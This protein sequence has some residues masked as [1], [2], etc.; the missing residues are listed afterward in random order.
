[1]ER[2]GPVCPACFR[3]VEEGAAYCG[4]CGHAI[5]PDAGRQPRRRPGLV[6]ILAVF[7]F[8]GGAGFLLIAVSVFAAFGNVPTD[9]RPAD[10]LVAVAAGLCFALVASAQIAGGIGL[11]RL[12]PHG[13]SIQR[14]FAILGLLLF[15]IG[16]IV[17]VVI[18]AYLNTAG[19]KL[20]F[21]RR[22]VS[23]LTEVEY[24]QLI[25]TM[26]SSSAA[27][28]MMSVLFGC[29]IIV[30][31]VSAV[32]VVPTWL[33]IRIPTS[34][35]SAITTLTRYASA[36]ADYA[37]VSQHGFG[38]IEC[39]VDPADCLPE[40]SGDPFLVGPPAPVFDDGRYLYQF[41]AGPPWGRSRGLER[42]ALLAVPVRP[43][44]TGRRLFCVDAA[45]DVLWSVG[46]PPSLH[47]AACPADWQPVKKNGGQ[48]L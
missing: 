25:R 42:Y 21:S 12:K 34:E 9:A 46:K 3:V 22:P 28:V 19:V 26:Q 47:T 41:T 2:P 24:D 7:Q 14:V 38:T 48:V 43:G 20:L 18:L 4:I 45:G 27:L 36:E 8:L 31:F 23:E 13:R 35:T 33:R 11:L 16:T 39:L 32:V 29:L 44:W 1:M 10:L 37:A 30:A 40:Y 6:T 17:S 15:P 5:A